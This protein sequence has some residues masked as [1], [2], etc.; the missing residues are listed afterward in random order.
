[1][2]YKLIKPGLCI[3][4]M[5]EIDILPSEIIIGVRAKVDLEGFFKYYAKN[6]YSYLKIDPSIKVSIILPSEIR[7]EKL[8]QFNPK[9][10][11]L[12]EKLEKLKDD[13]LSY[14]FDFKKN[15]ALDPSTEEVKINGEFYATASIFSDIGELLMARGTGIY[16]GIYKV[17]LPKYQAVLD[18]WGQKLIRKEELKNAE[19]YDYGANKLVA[20]KPKS[21]RKY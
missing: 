21:Q 3:N 20:L 19:L 18:F 6:T 7:D 4:S 5:R 12:S 16:L 9:Y 14:H 10:N 2:A 17:D 8:E 1:M 13:I 11:G 15:K